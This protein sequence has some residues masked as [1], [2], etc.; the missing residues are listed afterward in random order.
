M[1]WT[2]H[3]A[4]T[5]TLAGLRVLVVDDEAVIALE[6][7]FILTE[8]GAAVAGPAVMVEEALDLLR[9]GTAISAA[10]LD[11]R[12]GGESIET[13]AEALFDRQIPFVFYS[14][15][16]ETDSTLRRWPRAT[17]VSKPAPSRVLT[18]AIRQAVDACPF[19]GESADQID[20]P[21]PAP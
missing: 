20:S 13:V 1:S 19:S 8:A 6:I 15:Q 4:A 17:L 18:E 12:L 10:V 3:C 14:G 11:V 9:D 7:E 16:V 21:A 2:V 5:P